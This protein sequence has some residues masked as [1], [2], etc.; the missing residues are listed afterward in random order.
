ME[1]LLG[2]NGL[3]WPPKGAPGRSLRRPV[4]SRRRSGPRLDAQVA[5]TSSEARKRPYWAAAAIRRL[6]AEVFSA[7]FGHLMGVDDGAGRQ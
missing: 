3:F 7:S 1:A 4:D 6:S 2:Q 5:E